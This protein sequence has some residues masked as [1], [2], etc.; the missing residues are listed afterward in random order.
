MPA[1]LLYIGD[2]TMRFFYN[3][4]IALVI[5]AVSTA[6]ITY[7]LSLKYKTKEPEVE[8][9]NSTNTDTKLESSIVLSP[10]KGKVLPLSEVSM[11]LSLVR[12]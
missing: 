10:I 9:V 6:I 5:S 4:I 2:D 1:V 12:R 7:I 11:E 3:I 8:T